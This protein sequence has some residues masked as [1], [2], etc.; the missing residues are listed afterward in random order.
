M[1]L[2]AGI[3]LLLSGPGWALLGVTGIMASVAAW[4]WLRPE[5][6]R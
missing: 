3:L 2:S 4:L 1:A 6:A 5:P